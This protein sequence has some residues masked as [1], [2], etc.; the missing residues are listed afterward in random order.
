MYEGEEE[1]KHEGGNSDG[2]NSPNTLR[3]NRRF[4]MSES[5][6]II[7]TQNQGRSE[8]LS[9]KTT[10][11]KSWRFSYDYFDAIVHSIA[12]CFIKPE[13]RIV[14]DK[15][16]YCQRGAKLFHDLNKFKDDCDMIELVTDMKLMK[17]TVNQLAN[18][19]QELSQSIEAIQIWLQYQDASYP[20]PEDVS[21][22]KSDLLSIPNTMNNK[23]KTAEFPQ[24]GEILCI[25]QN[26]L[27]DIF[28]KFILIK[29]AL[30]ERKF[31]YLLRI[32]MWASEYYKTTSSYYVICV[33][34]RL[35]YL[36]FFIEFFFNN[37]K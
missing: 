17:R 8:K 18:Y 11:H 15:K 33:V 3:R 22:K 29:N 12:W 37:C 19:Y 14:T 4:E 24:N 31:Y 26:F 7:E 5:S 25:C 20:E 16:N 27:H 30:N 10:N 9:L 1:L 21:V 13:N 34:Y 23:F 32:S 36:F 35:Q 2:D 6:S 28:M